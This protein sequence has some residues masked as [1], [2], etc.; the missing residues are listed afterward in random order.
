VEKGFVE[1]STQSFVRKGAVML[2]NPLDKTRPALRTGLEET[3]GDALAKA[4]LYAPLVLPPK[5]EPKLFEVGSVFPKEG[6]YV[7]L[8]MTERVPNGEKKPA[9]RIISLSPILKSTVKGMRRSAMRSVRTS[10]SLRTPSFFAIS[11][12]GFRSGLSMI[13]RTKDIKTSSGSF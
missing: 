4:K 5:E 8:R 13:L 6:E 11:Q 9:F 3:L 12:S 2:A 7:E 1:V 10:H